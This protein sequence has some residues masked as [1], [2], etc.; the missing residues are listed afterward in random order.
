[1]TAAHAAGMRSIGFAN[2]PGKA[3]GL[4]QAG[5]NAIVGSDG[6]LAIALSL[7]QRG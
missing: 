4:S 3:G 7:R 2:H 6:M 1:M 5:A